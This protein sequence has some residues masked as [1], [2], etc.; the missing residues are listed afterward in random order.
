MEHKIKSYLA[1]GAEFHYDNS[2][3]L[4]NSP[5]VFGIAAYMKGFDRTIFLGMYFEMEFGLYLGRDPATDKTVLMSNGHF[6][7]GIPLHFMIDFLR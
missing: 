7:L 3:S 1:A 4:N 6:T 2:G 5:H